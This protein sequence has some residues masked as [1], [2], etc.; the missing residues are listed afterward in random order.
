MAQHKNKYATLTIKL[1]WVSFMLN[2][3][4]LS[5]WQV[6]QCWVSLCQVS[7]RQPWDEIGCEVSNWGGQWRHFSTKFRNRFSFDKKER[8][9]DSIRITISLTL[10]VQKGAPTFLRRTLF[11]THTHTHTQE[12]AH[13]FTS[14]NTNWRG[15]LSTVELLINLAC[16][17]KK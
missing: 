10:L 5:L 2:V 11:H 6:S 4:F 16:F 13:I 12:Q 9:D 15:R 7:Q 14:E 17:V 8:E 3:T 1:C